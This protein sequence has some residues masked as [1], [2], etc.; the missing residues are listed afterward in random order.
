[1]TTSIPCCPKT[2]SK[3]M[4]P[5]AGSETVSKTREAPALEMSGELDYEL[6]HMNRL[7]TPAW[8]FDID[9]SRVFWANSAALEVWRAANLRELTMRDM[10]SDMSASVARRLRQY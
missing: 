4:P 5:K 6:S 9:R 3:R 8:I 1:M 2:E 10:K 7:K